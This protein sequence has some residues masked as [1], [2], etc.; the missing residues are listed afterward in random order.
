[1]AAIATPVALHDATL[2]QIGEL[3]TLCVAVPQAHHDR[4]LAI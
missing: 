1:M 3:R 2:R 4:S